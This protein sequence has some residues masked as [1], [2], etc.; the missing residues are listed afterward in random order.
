MC[1]TRLVML[2]AATVAL[3]LVLPALASS[4]LSSLQLT[5]TCDGTGTCTVTD[6]N[7]DSLPVGTTEEYSG[8]LYGDPALSSRVVITVPGQDGGTAVGHCAWPLRTAAGTC[9]FAQG[10]GS[11]TGFHA[12][13][14][15]T[16]NADFSLFFWT[17]TYHF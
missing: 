3:S 2:A 17:G 6:T 4:P 10:T 14:T 7:T 12:N 15:V 16:A 1:R 11:L 9:T 5:K 13:V 8:P